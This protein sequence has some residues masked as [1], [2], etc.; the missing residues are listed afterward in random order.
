MTIPGTGQIDTIG[1]IFV[2]ITEKVNAENHLLASEQQYRSLI[3]RI[4]S[5]FALCEL[6]Y[7]QAGKPKDYRFLLVNKAFEEL[8]ELQ[9][10]GITGKT[11]LELMPDLEKIWLDVAPK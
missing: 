7:D 9:P 11:V 6:I 3:T 4:S 5:G 8:S 10:D 1:G 2:D